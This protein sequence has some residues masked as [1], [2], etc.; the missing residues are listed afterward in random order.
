MQDQGK[1]LD[2]LFRYA[3]S[4]QEAHAAVLFGDGS[5][6]TGVVRPGERSVLA[7]ST[8]GVVRFN[9]ETGQATEMYS[10][11]VRDERKGM[12]KRPDDCVVV[13]D[14]VFLC[15]EGALLL[16]PGGSGDPSA[17]SGTGEL[18][19]LQEAGYLVKIGAREFILG[20][21]FGKLWRIRRNAKTKSPD[22]VP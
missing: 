13:G 10:G 22:R 17:F 11:I 21:H 4:E 14:D 8:R 20:T 9:T 1:A 16:F 3:L 7:C 5:R 15:K 2:G 18:E 12:S 19:G 6:P